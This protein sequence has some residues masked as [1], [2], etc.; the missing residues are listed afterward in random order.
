MS[1]HRYEDNIN[2]LRIYFDTVIDWVSTVFIDV[3]PNMRDLNWGN[4]YEKYYKNPYNSTEISEKVQSLLGDPQVQDKRGI[5]EYILDG[6]KQVQLIKI[7][8]FDEVIKK[9]VYR[10]QTD[11]A[12][13]KAISNCPICAIGNNNN[14]IRIY[15]FNE[16]EADHVTAWSK[17]GSTDMSNCEM[18]CKSHNRAKGNR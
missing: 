4:F 7:R 15:K 10:K 3:L 1:R 11:F 17:G 6:E 14:K 16:M 18:L 2:E 8:V 9:S 5:F 13:D 12:K